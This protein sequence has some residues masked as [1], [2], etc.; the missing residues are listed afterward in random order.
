VRE[1][2]DRVAVED[3]MVRVGDGLVERVLADTDGTGAQIEL[4]DVDGVQRGTE[5]GRPAV[6]DVLRAHRVVL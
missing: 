3:A 1:I 6:Q 4:A 2:G 5:R